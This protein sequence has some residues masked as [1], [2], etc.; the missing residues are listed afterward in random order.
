[1]IEKK[2]IYPKVANNNGLN[3]EK[4]KTIFQLRLL[5]ARAAQTDSLCWWQDNSL[6]NEGNFVLERLFIKHS[7]S[8]AIR[9]SFAAAAARHWSAIQRESKKI[10]LFDF[11][12]ES[13]YRLSQFKINEDQVS[14]QR[15]ASVQELMQGIKSI[16]PSI[17]EIRISSP[18]T[19]GET[20]VNVDPESLIK[21]DPI[22]VYASALA[23]AYE[24][25]HLQQPVFPFIRVKN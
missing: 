23:L 8:A 4:A 22:F 17:I 14:L 6:T 15:I 3:S 13:E 1:M 2:L 25:A 16:L 7:H 11:G 10:H 24:Q 20:E 21:D 5:I 9:M 12:E 18:G 19:N